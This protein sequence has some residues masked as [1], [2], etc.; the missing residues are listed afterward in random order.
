MKLYFYNRTIY[1]FI[2]LLKL[3]DIF[4]SLDEFLGKQFSDLRTA[5]THLMVVHS[6]NICSRLGSI[7]YYALI[8]DDE[9]KKRTDLFAS[10][11][12]IS[13]Y[14][15]GY[16]GS[17]K[18]FLDSI[19]IALNDIHQL[20]LSNKLQ[21][22]SKKKF[23]E[24]LEA[25]SITKKNK[26]YLFKDLFDEVIK[27]RDMSVHRIKPIV[28]LHSPGPPEKAPAEKL[29]IKLLADYNQFGIIPSGKKLAWYKVL[30]LHYKWYPKF[31]ELCELICEDIKQYN[32]KTA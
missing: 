4:V 3:P 23:W 14:L 27:W 9:L 1:R 30:E 18:S 22:F 8:I 16:F 5:N 26:Y 19:S 32:Y 2:N 13:S 6:E 29:E 24:K 25:N 21:D 31:L 20:N 12:I 17:C 10:A 15:I 28:I 7:E 11:V